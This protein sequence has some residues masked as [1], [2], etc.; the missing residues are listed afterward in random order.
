M[1]DVQTGAH[2]WAERYDRDI[3]D[4]FAVQDEVARNVASILVVH[5]SKAEIERT[6]LKP[7]ASWRAYDYF[8]RAADVYA[9]FHRLMQA[10]AIHEA[11]CLL[12][13]CLAMEPG[14]A[15]AHVLYSEI[16][17]STWSLT[18]DDDHLNPAAIEN[19][20]WWAERAVQLDPNLPEAH[21]QLS[22]VRALARMPDAL[23]PFERAMQLNPN[24]NDRRCITTLTSIGQPERAINVAKAH[25]RVDPFALPIARGSL[26][27]AY[28]MLRR[29]SE[30]L[31]PL[32]EFVSQSP[33]HRPG[34][35]WLTVAYAH[36]GRIEDAQV[37]TGHVLRLDPDFLAAETFRKLTTIWPTG[38]VEDFVAGLR[39]AGL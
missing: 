6:L 20:H 23:A 33:N 32:T 2:R 25:L 13:Q 39:M 3:K 16:K 31:E 35:V 28:V 26:G 27:L 15:R 19:A 7:P 4:I 18:L 17:I 24:F 38:V 5:V 14:Y 37:Q 8:L 22:Y 34:R 12:D 1:I 11:R 10:P 36:L 29:Y 21:A 9:D 30:A